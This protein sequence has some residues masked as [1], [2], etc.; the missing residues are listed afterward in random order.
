MKMD[1]IVVTS[2][3]EKDLYENIRNQAFKE[4]ISMAELI[5]KACVDYINKALE[6]RGENIEAEKIKKSAP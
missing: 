3:I 4:R 5:R 2:H 6:V 1:K